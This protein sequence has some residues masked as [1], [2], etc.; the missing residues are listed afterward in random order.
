MLQP[1]VTELCASGRCFGCRARGPALCPGC[2]ARLAAPREV[3]TATGVDRVTCAWAYEGPARDLVL[4]LKLRAQ[5][6]AAVPLAAAAV[7]AVRRAGTEAS[8]VTWVP[9]RARDR[10]V[11]GFDH[12]ELL[13]RHVADSLGLPAVGLL[14]RADARPDQAGLS[15]AERRTNLR[16]AFVARPSRGAVLLVDD[17]VTTGA[18]GSACALALKGAGARWVDLAA[19]CR[20]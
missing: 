19:P 1:S 13:A 9:A 20:A 3:A 18:T 11:R 4:A 17:L 12:A 7:A 8:L 14:A 16:G 10:R 15:A 2:R 5:R 6:D